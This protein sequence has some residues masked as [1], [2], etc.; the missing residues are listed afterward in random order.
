MSSP[1]STPPNTTSGPSNSPPR[2]LVAEFLWGFVQMAVLG[3]LGI[4]VLLL[5]IWS[6][7][8]ADDLRSERRQ[9][10]SHVAGMNTTHRSNVESRRNGLKFV[11]SSL[12]T[13]SKA[14]P[15]KDVEEALAAIRIANS[16]ITGGGKL[17]ASGVNAPPNSPPG[18]GRDPNAPAPFSGN[19]ATDQ[20]VQFTRSGSWALSPNLLAQIVALPEDDPRRNEIAKLLEASLSR[21]AA[22][23]EYLLGGGQ[24]A[25]AWRRPSLATVVLNDCEKQLNRF[26]GPEFFAM[27]R[28]LA[29]VEPDNERVLR[30]LF[31]VTTPEMTRDPAG[32][33]DFAR[34]R[35]LG[36]QV[37]PLLADSPQLAELIGADTPAGDL[38]RGAVEF[39]PAIPE[40]ALEKLRE[41]LTDE[42]PKNREKILSWVAEG[43]LPPAVCDP[44]LASAVKL[45]NRQDTGDIRKD[46][47]ALALIT[48]T[49]SPASAS[50]I[51][52][53]ATRLEKSNP[54]VA[55]QL[56]IRLLLKY[57]SETLAVLV[58]S[59]DAGAPVSPPDIKAATWDGLREL[60]KG[61]I[62]LPHL[63]RPRERAAIDA[64]FATALSKTEPEEWTKGLVIEAGLWGG[65]V[66]LARLNAA[67]DAALA[68]AKLKETVSAAKQQLRRRLGSD[69]DMANQ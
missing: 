5:G 31:A 46:L 33:P 44:L 64:T 17:G 11:K 67:G 61:E 62:F 1:V 54:E 49:T 37:A 39:M 51:A 58:A 30:V 16:P 43:R 19:V 29:G 66:T 23:H 68:K 2:S 45:L 21:G 50:R 24:I 13:D 60:G 40:P 7:K 18:A 57:P 35:K 9:F 53:A 65:P 48:H 3:V 42:D 56:A 8:R 63:A 34:A 28:G 69:S 6:H 47:L 14:P 22:G 36:R 15:A 52:T 12:V 27:V 41:A 26:R 20:L 25:E 59:A 10:E 55:R 4:S 32:W 38:V